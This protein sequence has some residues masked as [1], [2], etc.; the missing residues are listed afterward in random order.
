[1][2]CSCKHRDALLKRKIRSSYFVLR[3]PRR[4]GIENKQIFSGNRGLGRRPPS[5]RPCRKSREANYVRGDRDPQSSHRADCRSH[6]AY[7]S[8]LPGFGGRR[9]AR[10]VYRLPFLPLSRD[11]SHL[12]RERGNYRTLAITHH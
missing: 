7:R 3:T 12:E 1:M 2:R 8:A 11:P 10:R 6:G 5:G 9:G 4:G